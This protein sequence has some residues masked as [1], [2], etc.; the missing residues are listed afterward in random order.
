MKKEFEE[1]LKLAGTRRFD[2]Q[3]ELL[4]EKYKDRPGYKNEVAA[5]LKKRL[6]ISAKKIEKIESEMNLKEQLAEVS[7][8]VSL[9]YISKTYFGKTRNWL[10]QRINGNLVNEKKSQFTDDELKKFQKALKDISK[11]I[12]AL[13]IG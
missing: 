10:Y 11:K 9:S 3:L 6:A 8:I 12:G 1:L 4:H 13:S 5:F 2:K 7:E